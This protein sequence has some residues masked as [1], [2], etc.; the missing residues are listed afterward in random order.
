[1]SDDLIYRQYK[2]NPP[3]LFVQ[4][5]KYF[6]TASTYLK[7]PFLV[8]QSSKSHLLESITKGC[9]KHD[10]MLEDWV[11]LDDHYHLMLQ[12]PEGSINLSKMISEIHRFTALWMKK[13]V[14]EVESAKRIF[15]NYWDS[16][17]TFERSYFARL[18]Y[19]YFNPVKH[20][21][22]EFPENYLFGSYHYRV[23]VEKEYLESLRRDYPWDKIK[24]KDDYGVQ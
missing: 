5:C 8:S 4:N 16:C 1:M 19:I 14:E 10:W 13:N 3:H 9:N 18:N 20:G 2:H 7:K 23:G 12:A 21:Y 11:I 22:V 17:I 24:V 6:I 15:W